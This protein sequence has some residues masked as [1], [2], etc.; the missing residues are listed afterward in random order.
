MV[1]EAEEFADE[2]KKVKDKIDARNGPEG[3]AYN[4]KNS[5]NDDEQLGDKLSEEDKETLGN[6]IDDCLDWLDEN[7]DADQ[8]EFDEQKEA[9][10]KVANPIIKSVYG[11]GAGGDDEEDDWDDEDDFGHDEL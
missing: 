4:L 9:L 5:I 6:A 3:Y 1:R 8:E 10:E 11:E 7:P 2:D